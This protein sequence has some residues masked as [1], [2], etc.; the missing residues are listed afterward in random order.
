MK[1][2]FCKKTLF[3]LEFYHISK[4]LE[5]FLWPCL[6]RKRSALGKNRYRQ[7]LFLFFPIFVFLLNKLRERNRKGESYKCWKIYILDVPIILMFFIVVIFVDPRNSKTI[8]PKY[9]G[10]FF[11]LFNF[12]YLIH[13]C[14]EY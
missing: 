3:F 8:S 7:I 9:L 5:D 11:S 6:R 13:F 2:D 1:N 10:S 14:L 12:V 4:T